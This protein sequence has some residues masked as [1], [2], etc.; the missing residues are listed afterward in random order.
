M[1]ASD[2]DYENEAEFAYRQDLFQATE[3]LYMELLSLED[4]VKEFHDL[5]RRVPK[6]NW[7]EPLKTLVTNLKTGNFSKSVRELLK[8]ST[9]ALDELDG[10]DE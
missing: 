8:K 7:P 2:S 10:I 9:A 4:I 3:L 5:I 6:K 1:P